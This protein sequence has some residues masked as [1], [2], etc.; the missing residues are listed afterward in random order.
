MASIDGDGECSVCAEPQRRAAAEALHP[1]GHVSLT[2]TYL[3]HV[4]PSTEVK[5]H[6]LETP[7]STFWGN[8]KTFCGYLASFV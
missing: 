2:H 7:T 3:V 8:L 4:G 1:E 5:T 6:T